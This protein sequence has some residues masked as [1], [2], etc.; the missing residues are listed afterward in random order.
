MNNGWIKIHRK[1]TEW[2]W[3][4]E[5]KTFALFLH[6]LLICNFKKT[7]WRGIELQQGE[8][9]HSL[10][11][12]AKDT[13][14][15]IQNIRTAISNMISTGELTE[16]QHN[17]YRILKITNYMKYQITNTDSN[18]EL[19]GIQQGANKEVTIDKE[20]KKDKNEKNKDISF[21]S[22]WNKYPKKVGKG[23][24]EKAWSKIKA[25]ATT[26]VEIIKTL[27]WQIGSAQWQE[28]GGRF[29]PNPA[30]Y[31]NRRSWEDEM[32]TPKKKNP[33]LV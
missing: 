22:F 6:L 4:T 29:I 16:R 28:D 5:T 31:L 11:R 15:S 8:T 9:I 32:P 20:R 25:P 26:L 23:A 13:G 14:L 10:G 2:E 12:L 19:T 21:E 17:K 24:A 33:F 3:Y 1:I 18:I 7:S 30:T 27:E